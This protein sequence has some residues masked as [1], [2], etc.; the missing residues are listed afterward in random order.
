M[1]IHLT[2]VVKDNYNE[3]FKSLK[4]E[5]DKYMKNGNNIHVTGWE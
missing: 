3:Q 1:E 4:K 5:I 2:N